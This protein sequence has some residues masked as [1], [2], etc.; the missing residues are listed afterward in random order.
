MKPTIGRIVH[1]VRGATERPA[2]IVHVSTDGA[3]NLQ[4]FNDSGYLGSLGDA[5]PSVTWETSVRYSEGGENRTWHWPQ[6]EH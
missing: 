4:V 2:I 5:L 3:V 1:F 6:L